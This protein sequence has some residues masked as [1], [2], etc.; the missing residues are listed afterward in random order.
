MKIRCAPRLWQKNNVRWN[1]FHARPAGC[2]DHSYPRPAEGGHAREVNAVKAAGQHHVGE[3]QS[4][5]GR[6]L[7]EEGECFFGR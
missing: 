2:Y 4:H 7:T 1:V 6:V 5:I 3:N